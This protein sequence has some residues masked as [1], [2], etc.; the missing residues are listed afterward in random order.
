MKRA[1]RAALVAVGFMSSS[2][3]AS[4]GQINL[5]GEVTAVSCTINGGAYNRTVR[6]PTVNATVLSTLG[7]SAGYA[8]FNIPLR[9]CA[10]SAVNTALVHF[11]AGPTVDFATG[12][13]TN[14]APGG[15]NVQV[16][17]LDGNNYNVLRLN[18]GAGAQGLTPVVISMGS[19]DVNLVARYI[20]ATGPATAGPVS[21]YVTFSIAYN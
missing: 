12:N 19:A 14:Q 20:A 17:L 18:A 1:L 11:E 13:L 8:A 6:M 5:N 2:A 15:S 7:A 3:F 10:S 9:G 16:Q 4:D 21:T